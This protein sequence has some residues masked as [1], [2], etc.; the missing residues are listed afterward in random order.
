MA[1]EVPKHWIAAP[2]KHFGRLKGGA[3]FPHD[4]QGVEGE[5]LSFHKVNALGSCFTRRHASSE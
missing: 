5:E 2:I 4:Q 3:G 1:G